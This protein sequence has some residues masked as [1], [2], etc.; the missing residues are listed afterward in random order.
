M[1]S[2]F[3]RQRL[4]ALTKDELMSIIRSPLNS[5][6]FPHISISDLEGRSVAT[7]IDMIMA[8]PAAHIDNNIISDMRHRGEAETFDRLYATALQFRDRRNAEL[9]NIAT[10]QLA[11]IIG[12]AVNLRYLPPGTT[13][14]DIQQMSRD[15]LLKLF[16]KYPILSLT[17]DPN[18]RSYDPEYW[19]PRPNQVE[20]VQRLTEGLLKSTNEARG[21]WDGT[22]TG[23]GKTA[24]GILTAIGLKVRYVLIVCPDPVVRKWHDALRPLGL[25][26]YKI[27]TYAGIKGTEPNLAERWAKHKPDPFKLTYSEDLE[28]VKIRATGLKGINDATYDWSHLPN[29]DP[30]TG[31]GGCLVIWDEVHNAKGT[32]KIGVCFNHFVKYLHS[33]PDKF[34]R[35]LYLSGSIMETPK[36]LPYIMHALGYIETPS[37]GI[38]NAFIRR[39]LNA[40]LRAWLADDWEPEFENIH[41]GETKLLLFLRIVASRQKKFSQIPEALPYTAYTL[42]LIPKPTPEKLNDFIDETLVPNFRNLMQEDWRESM[43]GLD[44]KKK[45]MQ[46]LV[47]LS[48]NPRFAD[49]PIKHVLET[50]F[51]NPITFQGLQIRDEELGQ[52]IRINREIEAMLLEI[53]RGNKKFDGGILGQIQRTLSELE[54]LK[55]TPFTE[56]ARKALVTPLA[57][58]AK[59]SVVISMLRNAS[60]RHFAWRMEA[61]LFIEYLKTLNYQANQLNMIQENIIQQILD[62]HVRYR[63]EEALAI[64][65]DQPLRI[66]SSFKQYTR[67]QLSEMSF[68]DLVNE[69]NK[70]IKYL[71]V[72]KFEYV[73]IFVS[74]FG[75][76]NPT[77]F[78]LDSPDEADHIK[79]GKVLSRR[80]KEEVKEMFQTNQRRVFITNIMISREGIDLHDI[81][82]GGMHPRT[83]IISPGIVARYL[84][85]M[86]GRF[87]REG[88][89][90]ESIRI[91]GY[92]DNV[93]GIPSWEARF[94][95]RLSKKV[96]DLQ[97]LHSGEVSLDILD[98]I[99][100]DGKSILGEIVDEMRMGVGHRIQDSPQIDIGVGG[101]E[102]P[103]VSG[104]RDSISVDSQ[105]GLVSVPA[106]DA[107]GAFFQ[108][109]LS[110]G[111]ARSG[112]GSM[113]RQGPPIQQTAQTPSAP[114]SLNMQV[115]STHIYFHSKNVGLTG[116]VERI[117]G[118]LESMKMNPAYYKALT[119]LMSERGPGVLIYRPGFLVSGLS[120]TAMV[121]QVEQIAPVV[122][123]P[124]PEGHFDSENFIPAIKI[125]RLMV[126]FE[127]K[128][129]ILV[130]PGYPLQSMFPSDLL[131]PAS[132][133]I[134]P[135]ANGVIKFHGTTYKILAAYYAIKM[136]ALFEAANVF[137]SFVL[138][139]VRKIIPTIDPRFIL[140]TI[141]RDGKYLVIAD[142]DLI[143]VLGIIFG[144]FKQLVQPIRDGQVFDLNS[145]TETPDG[146]ATVEVYPA[147][148]N[149]A[150]RFIGAPSDE[151]K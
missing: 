36:D 121:G 31:L 59:G 24:A 133:T 34:I 97:L 90:S 10:E 78:D 140:K 112:P 16:A 52:F 38:L 96:K 19:K 113:L 150:T 80:T 8:V 44:K 111:K 30:A 22:K 3:R 5:A 123:I 100:K 9:Q 58:G 32:S 28:W 132:L 137:Q 51:E 149:L 27:C 82:E 73:C 62:E 4:Q 131:A 136:I 144:T 45:F 2:E 79:E 40:K 77:D 102:S 126:I 129:S 20:H 93:K 109:T 116:F 15:Q 135:V 117:V 54:V 85:Q 91:I 146:M 14:E 67:Q 70:W 115:N 83:G 37:R 120:Q 103:P 98:N 105:P 76:P 94:M 72:D 64:Q 57:G 81:S 89:T 130:G 71:D 143:R 69:Y 125:Q 29:T 141:I 53:V 11:Y 25:F 124:V 99:D 134:E 92:V 75:N 21:A 119:S 87:V 49:I 41:D 106:T 88:Q 12:M 139:D 55:L 63:Q 65:N 138:Q 39:E 18:N 86:L 118:I 13:V 147:Y 23:L 66:K 95:V 107:V 142:R 48:K 60:V 74:N 7:M 56:L 122:N 101:I 33:E 145:Y 26:E 84:I 151:K 1:D 110:A 104:H 35:G 43:E 17:G 68:E 108:R 46:F 114:L 42:R 47:H 148:Q 6:H 61:I 127:S 128:E 50:T